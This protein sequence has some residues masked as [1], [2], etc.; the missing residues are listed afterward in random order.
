ME[1]DYAQGRVPAT[2]PD[3]LRWLDAL[4][5]EEGLSMTAKAVAVRLF[6][7]HRDETGQCNPQQDTIAVDIGRGVRSVN[8]AIS[9]LRKA[10]WIEVYPRQKRADYV[11]VIARADAEPAAKVRRNSRARYAESDV[12]GTQKVAYRTTQGNHQEN[13]PLNHRTGRG[14]E[15]ARGAESGSGTGHAGSAGAQP[16]DAGQRR[17]QAGSGDEWRL[18]GSC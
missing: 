5:A 6:R 10:G 15:R 14:R 13:H 4:F 17:H 8:S 12:S 7:H 3:K 2:V 18:A 11:L 9:E 16:A 1:I